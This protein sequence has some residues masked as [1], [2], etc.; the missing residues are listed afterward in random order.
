MRYP[1]REDHD[2]T[3]EYNEAVDAYE[4]EESRREEEAL[5]RYYLNKYGD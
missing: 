5:E 1:R 2:S 4:A 3:E